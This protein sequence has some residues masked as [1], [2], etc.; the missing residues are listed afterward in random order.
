MIL[1]R[2]FR[3][4]KVEVLEHLTCP[5]TLCLFEEPVVAEDGYTYEKAAIEDWVAS[6][7]NSTKTGR[8]MGKAWVVDVKKKSEILRFM[9]KNQ[10][11]TVFEFWAA[12]KS[13]IVSLLAIL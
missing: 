1:T 11:C 13:G 6:N 12:V 5:I 9:K 2:K 3:M 4:P 8:P 10:L 7:V